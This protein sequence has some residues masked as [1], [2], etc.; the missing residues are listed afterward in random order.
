[1]EC[2]MQAAISARWQRLNLHYVVVLLP[3]IA[4]IMLEAHIRY[5]SLKQ[6]SA[7]L[8]TL[9]N[10]QLFLECLPFLAAHALAFKLPLKRSVVVWLLG[11]V[12]YPSLVYLL[13]IM[14][15][16]FANWQYLDAQCWILS[17]FASLIWLMLKRVSSAQNSL[18]SKWFN[19]LTSLD[20]M[21][22]LVLVS[23]SLIM[24]GVLNTHTNPMLNQPLDLI[25][26]IS[27]V[28][29][30][31]NQFLTY[32]WQLSVYTAI[33]FCLYLFNRYILIR[34]I[35]TNHGV[36]T[37]L[38]ACLIFIAL[39]TPT[40]TAGVLLLPIN[41]LP[42]EVVNLTPSGT[43]SLFS[44]YN[45]QFMFFFLSV[46][47]PIILAFERQQQHN[48]LNVIAKQQTETELTLLQQQINPHFLFNTLNNLYALTLTKSDNAPQLVMQLANLLRY[49]VYEGQKQQ[50]FL[51][52][53]INYL[54]DFIELQQI[55]SGDKCQFNLVWP[56]NPGKLK[57]APLLLIIILEN[58]IKHGVEPTS[59]QTEI[60]FELTVSS[61]T[62]TLY[63]ANTIHQ[64]KQQ[65]DSGMGLNNLKRRLELLYPN[66]YSLITNSQHNIWH[67]TLTL[68][69]S[70]C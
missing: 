34:Q 55:R 6:D 13:N 3:V 17:A 42:T 26:D 52:Q 68:E 23:W 43:R 9:I 32:F 65:N 14:S 70:S 37:F 28:F 10:G 40:L 15:S 31:F 64:Q 20:N 8:Y 62:L 46:S 1:M 60:T 16:A 36:F 5:L 63:C 58:A 30:Q 7:E 39:L 12:A 50:V 69:L 29:T 45:Y 67:T 57:I 56:S 59:Q 25:L 35:L 21:V 61:N 11:F 47:T 19:S 51:T 33:I 2:S 48:K 18:T 24:A 22:I 66:S 4:A 41:D 27:K 38:A 44:K 53:E 54:K 49:T